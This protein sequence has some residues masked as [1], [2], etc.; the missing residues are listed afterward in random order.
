MERER[1][2]RL[3]RHHVARAA[4]CIVCVSRAL[5]GPPDVLVKNR[6]LPDARCYRNQNCQACFVRGHR[7]AGACRFYIVPLCLSA[8]IA[9]VTGVIRATNFLRSGESGVNTDQ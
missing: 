5:D 2:G 4:F 3:Y 6:N 1:I 9:V 7:S 8:H